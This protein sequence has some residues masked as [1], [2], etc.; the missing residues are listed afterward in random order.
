MSR[1]VS[2]ATW[3][4]VHSGCRARTPAARS[5]RVLR[6]KFRPFANRSERVIRRIAAI[7][8]GCIGS[9]GMNGGGVTAENLRRSVHERKLVHVHDESAGV[10]GECGLSIRAAKYFAMRSMSFVFGGTPQ[11]CCVPRLPYYPSSIQIER[12]TFRAVSPRNDWA[13]HAIIADI[14]KLHV[15]PLDD[16]ATCKCVFAG[17]KGGAE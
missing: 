14:R 7:C 16:G 15:H 4:S 2:S 3:D 1:L 13:S 8:T 10:G 9:S 6:R 17:R 12:V 11:E 5:S